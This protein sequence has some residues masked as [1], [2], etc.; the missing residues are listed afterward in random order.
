[1]VVL[2]SSPET[3]PV[4][5]TQVSPWEGFSERGQVSVRLFDRLGESPNFTDEFR[6]VCNTLTPGE[7]LH[8]FTSLKFMVRGRRR[9]PDMFQSLRRLGGKGVP[10]LFDFSRNT[11]FMTDRGTLGVIRQSRRPKTL[12]PTGTN[13][14][15]ELKGQAQDITQFLGLFVPAEHRVPRYSESCSP[16]AQYYAIWAP[17]P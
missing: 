7:L 16:D 11:V 1:M 3:T 10:W 12:P 15:L 4:E 5:L 13:F 6:R 14:L 17:E 2:K 8:L 9:W